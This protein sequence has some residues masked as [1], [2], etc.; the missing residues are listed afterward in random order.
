MA[1][2]KARSTTPDVEPA[3]ERRLRTQRAA[4]IRWAGEDP[5]RAAAAMTRGRWARFERQVDPEG[6]LTHEERQR[7]AK[8]AERAYMVGLALRSAQVRRARKR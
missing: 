5:T 6:V 4:L 2:T 8:A 1:T 7:R 3:T